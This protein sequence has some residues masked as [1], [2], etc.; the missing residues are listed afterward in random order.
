MHK[1]VE[2]NYHKNIFRINMIWLYFL[3][4]H[5]EIDAVRAYHLILWST[6]FLKLCD[7]KNLIEVFS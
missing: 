2:A 6:S 7:I 4:Y 3:R 1:H 5:R